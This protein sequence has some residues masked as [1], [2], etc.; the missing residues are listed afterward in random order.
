MSAH[1]LYGK[2]GILRAV[3]ARDTAELEGLERAIPEALGRIPRILGKAGATCAG[4]A[5]CLGVG[6]THH[7]ERTEVVAGA[8]PSRSR[9]MDPSKGS[10]RWTWPSWLSYLPRCDHWAIGF[11]ASVQCTRRKRPASTC[12]RSGRN[13]GVLAAAAPVGMWLTCCPSSPQRASLMVNLRELTNWA[14]RQ[15]SHGGRRDP[16][17]ARQRRIS[18]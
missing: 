15:G 9:A 13:G 3:R 11:W 2:P 8:R 14:E 18:C 17:P 12:T 1:R 4:G 7:Q 6:I 10:N 16:Y 5:Q